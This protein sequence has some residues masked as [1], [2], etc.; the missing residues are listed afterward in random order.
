MESIKKLEE[1]WLMNQQKQ[2]SETIIIGSKDGTSTDRV[3]L[4]KL[5]VIIIMQCR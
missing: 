2:G 5:Y 3:K 1:K 4:N